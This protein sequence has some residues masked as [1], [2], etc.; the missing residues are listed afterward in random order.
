MTMTKED[1]RGQSPLL[2]RYEA[3]TAQPTLDALVSLARGLHVSL[4]TGI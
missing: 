1:K 3:G 2:F 4:D